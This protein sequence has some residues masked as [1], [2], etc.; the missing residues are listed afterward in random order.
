TKNETHDPDGYFMD[1]VYR[2]DISSTTG[3]NYAGYRVYSKLN[4]TIRNG[5]VDVMR[6]FK[7]SEDLKFDVKIGG[8]YQDRARQ[9]DIRQLGYDFFSYSGVNGKEDGLLYLPED[10]IFASENLS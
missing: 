10:Q 1:T 9:F 4:E 3:P 8:L 2:A 7:V 5:K 6:S